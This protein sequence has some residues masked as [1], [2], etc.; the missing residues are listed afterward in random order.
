MIGRECSIGMR[1]ALTLIPLTTKGDVDI[2]KT[3]IARMVHVCIDLHF[4]ARKRHGEGDAGMRTARAK[5]AQKGEMLKS[6]RQRKTTSKLCMLHRVSRN[7]EE[8]SIFGS[9]KVCEFG[10]PDNGKRSSDTGGGHWELNDWNPTNGIGPQRSCPRTLPAER[11][12]D[13]SDTSA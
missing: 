9:S 8:R 5:C 12:I 6:K 11:S 7:I 2:I 3:N 13:F 4:T 10:S 1:R